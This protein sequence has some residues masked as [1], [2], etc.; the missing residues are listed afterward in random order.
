[1]HTGQNKLDDI[2]TLNNGGLTYHDVALIEKCKAERLRITEEMR[3]L[4]RLN[5]RKYADRLRDLKRARGELTD[6]KLAEKFECSLYAI[7]LIPEK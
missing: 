2:P 7:R 4:S 3:L 1:M 5:K 6:A